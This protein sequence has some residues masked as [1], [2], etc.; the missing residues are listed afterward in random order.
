MTP[1]TKEHHR[2]GSLTSSQAYTQDA[3]A[4][5]PLIQTNSNES[6]DERNA[7]PLTNYRDL[8][9][10]ARGMRHIHTESMDNLVQSAAPL[11]GSHLDNQQPTLP[12]MQGYGGGYRGTDY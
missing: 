5:S 3:K 8:T 12:R 9:P 2:T 6:L 10:Q 1:G 11:D 4:L 7:V